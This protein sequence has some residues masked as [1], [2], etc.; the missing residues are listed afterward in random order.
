MVGSPLRR[1]ATDSFAPMSYPLAGVKNPVTVPA[2][3]N[4]PSGLVKVFRL[5]G[6]LQ[7][8]VAFAWF[9]FADVSV[10]LCVVPP[11]GVNENVRLNA[12]G[13]NTAVLPITWAGVNSPL[14]ST[15]T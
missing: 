6:M 10:S 15:D 5:A 11:V 14:P 1:R 13:T 2:M 9:C 7:V 8:T 4:V 3:V 12:V